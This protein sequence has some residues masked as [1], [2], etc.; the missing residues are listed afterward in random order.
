MIRMD[1]ALAA[2]RLDAQMLLQVHDE[3]V[4]EAPLDEVETSIKLI[5]KVM[6]SAPAAGAEADGAVAGRRTRGGQLGRGALTQR[7]RR[8][9]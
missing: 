6:A 8:R 3:L 1:D 7:R 9:R 5:S 2:A 4:F